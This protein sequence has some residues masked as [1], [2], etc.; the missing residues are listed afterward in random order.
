MEEILTESKAAS[1]PPP[2]L[3]PEPVAAPSPT[4]SPSQRASPKACFFFASGTCRNGDS[5]RFSHDLTGSIGDIP[6]S[7]SPTA[8]PAQAM[9]FQFPPPVLINISPGHPVYSVDVECVAT[10]VQHN[11]R[12]IAQVAL[13]DEWSRLVFS[14]YVKQDIPVVSHITELTGLTQEVL[15]ANGIPLGEINKSKT[16]ES[17]WMLVIIRASLRFLPPGCCSWSVGL[18]QSSFTTKC[19]SCWPKYWQRHPMVAARWRCRLL[20]PDRHLHTFPGLE[21]KQVCALRCRTACDNTNNVFYYQYTQ[22]F[23]S[24]SPNFS[25][26]LFIPQWRIYELFT[27]P[28]RKGKLCHDIFVI[29]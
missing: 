18:T 26:L 23:S 16:L 21:S 15:D 28:L 17:T 12:S 3:I 6:P 19:N 11:A 9:Q 10:G 25:M 5:C 24:I 29:N 4:P 13:V 8:A 14:V 2:I 22:S 20:F 27:R 7:R 1:P